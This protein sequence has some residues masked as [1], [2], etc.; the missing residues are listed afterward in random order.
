LKEQKE[1][2]E[3]RNSYHEKLLRAK[4]KKIGQLELEVRNLSIDNFSNNQSHSIS[5]FYL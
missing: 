1:L 3:R 5:Y 2:S 4:N